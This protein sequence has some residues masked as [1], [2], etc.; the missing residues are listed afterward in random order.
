M[1][2][3]FVLV[4]LLL[5]LNDQSAL[6]QE[7][8][9]VLSLGDN[10][11]VTVDPQ[12]TYTVTLDAPPGTAIT[13]NT[14]FSCCPGFDI[15]VSDANGAPIAP[16]AVLYFD[17][18]AYL[19]EGQPPF[20][21]TF[22]PQTGNTAVNLDITL[23]EQDRLTED[24]LLLTWNTPIS[25]SVADQRVDTYSFDASAQSRIAIEYEQSFSF[26]LISPD[27]EHINESSRE[28]ATTENPRAA[29]FFVLPTTGTYRLHIFGGDYAFTAASE[30][31]AP[32]LSPGQT[33]E[34]VFDPAARMSFVLDAPP[35]TEVTIE[36][37]MASPGALVFQINADGSFIRPESLYNDMEATT[38]RIPFTM[39]AA[40][41]PVILLLDAGWMS[42][43]V[44]PQ[45]FS[46]RLLAGD[47]V[48]RVA[49]A[50]SIG[51]EV[52]GTVAQDSIVVHPLDAPTGSLLTLEFDLSNRSSFFT[53]RDS[54]G[55]ELPYL[56][57]TE[58]S[59]PNNPDTTLR[60][61]VSL[62]E[63]A[64]YV[65]YV[66]PFEVVFNM[67]VDY[68]LRVLAG[69]QITTTSQTIRDEAIL[70]GDVA[71]GNVAV[72]LLEGF[73]AGESITLR[74]EIDVSTTMLDA[75]DRSILPDFLSLSGSLYILEGTPPYR[76]YV[77]TFEQPAYEIAL[78]RGDD[79]RQMV[80]A[81]TPGQETRGSLSEGV[82][83]LHT[84]ES[85]DAE[86]ITI[87][88]QNL[89]GQS[90]L[91]VR[92][93]DGASLSAHYRLPESLST[94]RFVYALTG[95]DSYTLEVA[96]Y[97]GGSAD[98]AFTVETGNALVQFRAPLTVENILTDRVADGQIN[99]HSLEVEQAGRYL[100]TFFGGTN[101]SY[102]LIDATTRQIM[103]TAAS[104]QYFGSDGTEY[105]LYSLGAAAYELTLFNTA[106]Y[107]ILLTSDFNSMGEEVYQFD[108]S[109]Q[110]VPAAPPRP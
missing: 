10:L 87:A 16:Q 11:Y 83:N 109:G 70:Q 40:G 5:T 110:L 38:H 31:S 17:L 28:F 57:L 67:P 58:V 76:L 61:L 102:T 13:L 59:E 66:P 77:Q 107:T 43:G 100:L 64:P 12:T 79:L 54:Q 101:A 60:A 75:T 24:A 68:T 7:N 30:G 36:L 33:I 14:L 35:N 46:L 108:A 26:V 89:S 72:Y 27:G 20:T 25:G 92:D 41:S 47:L 15:I 21:L 18:N 73:A 105:I 86:F 4:L 82:T 93:D 97:D 51:D 45:P 81:V 42:D 80:S 99:S 90:I 78:T 19:L 69:D 84:L 104:D 39:P 2:H 6:A 106:E 34:N 29:Q 63:T 37:T 9:G 32:V 8:L 52:S 56:F 62:S 103:T 95:A 48:T 65:T 22:Q 55:Q 23:M 88:F 53:L 44:S 49:E 50:V 96:S 91:S 98:Y 71:R 3:V 94:E 74:H 85:V 1:R